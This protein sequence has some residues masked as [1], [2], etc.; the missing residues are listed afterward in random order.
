MNPAPAP[1]GEPAVSPEPRGPFRVL[2]LILFAGLL[3]FGIT[4]GALVTRFSGWLGPGSTSLRPTSS[5]VVAVRDLARLESA[6]YHIERVIDLK[7]KQSRFMGLVEAEDGILLVASGSV[8]A[9]V[10]LSKVGERDIQIDEA[11]SSLRIKLPAPEILSSRLDNERTYVHTRKTDLLAKR[12][13]GLESRARQ[14]AEKS[15]VEAAKESGIL[16]RARKNSEQT[17]RSLVRSL[18]YERVD[19]SFKD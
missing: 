11:K 7:Q 12:G 9:G 16:S 2:W 10:D 1:V 3:L 19:V 18:G 6:E 8:T 4:V 13:E 17:V 5:V 14:E 15:I